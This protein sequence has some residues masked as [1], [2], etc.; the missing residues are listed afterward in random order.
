MMLFHAF[1]VHPPDFLPMSLP[2]ESLL[3]FVVVHLRKGL[4][5][6]KKSVFPLALRP[7]ERKTLKGDLRIAKTFSLLFVRDLSLTK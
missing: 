6:V 5:K 4:G 7:K 2:S 3:W 1:W